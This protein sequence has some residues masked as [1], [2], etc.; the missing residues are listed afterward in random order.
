MNKKITALKVQKKNQNRVNVYLDGEFAFGLSRIVAGWLHIGQ[1]ITDEKII[2]LQVEDE[3]E[4]AYQRAIRFSGYRMR[5]NSEITQYLKQQ[6][7]SEVNIESVI[8]RL[9]RNGVLNDKQFASMWVDNRNEFRPRSHR[10]LF[11]ELRKK[12]IHP[13]IINQ[14]LEDNLSDEELAL[15]AAEN[16]VRKYRNLEWQDYRR[17]LSSYLARRGF[18]YAI[19][20]PV[21]NQVWAVRDSKN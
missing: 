11:S 18:S 4:I 6:G 21:V 12:G 2:N 8:N 15:L 5:S 19:I 13:D 1:E 14:V 3:Q 7:T 20:N 10:M 9:K 16:Q 17:K